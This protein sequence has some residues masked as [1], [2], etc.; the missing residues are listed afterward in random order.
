[1]RIKL[2]KLISD[3][4]SIISNTKTMIHYI[5]C[6][7]E[8][9]KY[10]VYKLFQSGCIAFFP[11]ALMTLPG[12]LINT[13]TSDDFDFVR[14]I[15][16]LSLILTLSILYHFIG[17]FFNYRLKK[18]KMQIDLEIDIKFF[19]HL[20]SMDYEIYENPE[21]QISMSRSREALSQVWSVSDIFIW[22]YYPDNQFCDCYSSNFF[23]E[24]CINTNCYSFFSLAF[25]SQ[26]T[27]QS[28][29]V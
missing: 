3:C 28:K 25:Q 29:T 13:L 9:N 8:G 7:K 19:R 4:K 11:L 24:S 22:I 5:K 18:I 23:F 1:M 26:E 21:I 10:F 20:M 27:D 6:E 17:V 12:L 15:V 14:C 2:H 16:Y